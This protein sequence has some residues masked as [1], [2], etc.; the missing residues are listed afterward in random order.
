METRQL[1]YIL[2][3]VG[4]VGFALYAYSRW[5]SKSTST[6]N[7]AD[8]PASQSSQV[9]VFAEALPSKVFPDFPL[10]PQ[11]LFSEG[12]VLRD[13]HLK[14]ASV[15]CE[16]ILGEFMMWQMRAGP[17]RWP[18]YATGEMNS[19]TRAVGNMRKKFDSSLQHT[20]DTD[21]VERLVHQYVER[22]NADSDVYAKFMQRQYTIFY[23]L[24]DFARTLG[25]A[26]PAKGALESNQ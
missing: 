22:V 11:N 21:L 1:L 24:V 12:S 17:G 4:I 14:N 18:E 8:A 26:S 6:G 5:S 10:N 9:R 16:C 2:I 23:L 19:L 25:A 3:A 13:I 15:I 7:H 20:V